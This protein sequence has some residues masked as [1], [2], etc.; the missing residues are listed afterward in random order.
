ME[1]LVVSTVGTVFLSSYLALGL[2]VRADFVSH[3]ISVLVKPDFRSDNDDFFLRNFDRLVAFWTEIR[4]QIK[5]AS[6]YRIRS[7]DSAL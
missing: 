4:A 6:K 2:G 7:I 5:S 3:V 1:G